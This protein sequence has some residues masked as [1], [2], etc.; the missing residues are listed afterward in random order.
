MKIRII[1]LLF[2]IVLGAV[3]AFGVFAYVTSIKTSVEEKVEKVQV[4]V[5]GRNIPKWTPVTAIAKDISL[6]GIPREYLVEGVLTSLDKYKGHVTATQIN[7]GEQITSTKFVLPE[8]AGLAFVIPDGLVAVSIQVDE[9]IGV[10]NLINIGDRV[11]VIA[12][13]EEA[14]EQTAEVLEG[15][16][17]ITK[18][19]L[20]NVQVL[21]VGTYVPSDGEGQEQKA[22]PAPSGQELKEITTITL[23]VTPLQAEKLVFSEDMGRVRLALLPRKGIEET[24]TPG[25]FLGNIFE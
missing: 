2:A 7:K 19:L 14:T 4:L 21:Y 25:R 18:T 16:P 17:A 8:Q 1:L 23:A 20:W 5:A 13:F 24:A 15:D 12:T 6:A 9:V 22:F 10:S 11:N 3:A